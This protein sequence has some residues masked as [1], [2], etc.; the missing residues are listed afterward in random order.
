MGL[1]SGFL[2]GIGRSK[3]LS[4]GSEGTKEF[5]VATCFEKRQRK[6]RIH[7]QCKEMDIVDK[8]NN[9]ADSKWDLVRFSYFAIS[10]RH[11]VL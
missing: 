9:M 2:K 10:H 3:R 7:S 1:E 11:K 5:Y 6:C 4:L 8:H